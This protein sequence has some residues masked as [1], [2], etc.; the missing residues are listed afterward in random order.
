M[1][2][3]L[4]GAIVTFLFTIATASIA[5]A[6]IIFMYQPELPEE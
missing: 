1:K 5:S 6:C 2:K 3:F 4:L